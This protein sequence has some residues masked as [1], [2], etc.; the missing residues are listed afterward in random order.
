MVLIGNKS[1]ME[2]QRAVPVDLV[3]QVLQLPIN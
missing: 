3:K 1:D 2:D